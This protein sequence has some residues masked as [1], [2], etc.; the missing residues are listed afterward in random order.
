MF[1]KHITIVGA[2]IVGLSTA[3]ALLKQGMKHITVLEQATVAHDR[4]A[5]HGLSRLIRPE[6]GAKRF[7]TEM[8]QS[9]F[10]LWTSLEQ[11]MQRT[12]Y[13]P[14]GLLTLGHE[15]DGVTQPSY[16]SL[17]EAGYTPER[18]TGHTCMQRF[19]QFNTQSYDLFIYNTE[20][21]MLHASTCLQTLKGAILDL[22][23][24]ILETSRVIHITHDKQHLPLGLY[25]STGEKL[26]AD[27]VVLATGPWVH[28]MLGGLHLPIRLTRQYAFYFA[29]LE[30]ATFGLNTFPA[31]I[32]DDLYGFPIYSTCTGSGPSWL[33][34]TS[35]AFGATVAPDELPIID[36]HVIKQV[37]MRLLDLIPDLRHAELAYID[38]CIYDVSP[39][40]DFI[41]DQ[42][43][44]DPRIIFA[45]GLSGHGFKFGLLLGE[46]LS[47]MVCEAEY[48]I[49]LENFRLARFAN[50]THALSVV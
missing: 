30:S 2:G 48:P 28:Q 15:D 12:L 16:D 45:T 49:S 8:V 25:L 17:W 21:G 29:N 14:T 37:T 22:G 7:Y 43:P 36:E 50:K 39:D 11:R 24:T 47:S 34:A 35:H 3:F 4:G 46:M 32:A 6:Y 9:S 40:E 18:L 13:T 5:S 38:T 19:P 31:F 44:G 27:Q 1:Q 26:T 23:G 33:K 42:Y 20:A 41:L 10:K